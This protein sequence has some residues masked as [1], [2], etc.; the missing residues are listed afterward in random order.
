MVGDRVSDKLIIRGY[1]VSY[2]NI[3]TSRR[4]QLLKICGNDI[5]QQPGYL[6]WVQFRWLQTTTQERAQNRDRVLLDNVQITAYLFQQ[7]HTIFTDE[8][9]IQVNIK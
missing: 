3:G 6:N 5:A 4:T 9:E 2:M 7:Q 8:F 1:N